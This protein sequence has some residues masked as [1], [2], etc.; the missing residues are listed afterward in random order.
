MTRAV[1]L[2]KSELL[3]EK[4]VD[5]VWVMTGAT[6]LTTVNLR[7]APGDGNRFLKSATVVTNAL[8]TNVICGI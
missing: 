8:F 4:G 1:A 5:V 3:P 6:N 7:A 2:R